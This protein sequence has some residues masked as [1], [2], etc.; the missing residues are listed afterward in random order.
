MTDDCHCEMCWLSCADI[1]ECAVNNGGC[2]RT[3][4]N[5]LGGFYCD[6]GYGYVK[7]AKTNG[8][9]CQRKASFAASSCHMQ[10]V[11]EVYS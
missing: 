2:Q 9:K 4:V 11:W 7:D 6:C 10:V 1:N 5:T 8:T 3:C